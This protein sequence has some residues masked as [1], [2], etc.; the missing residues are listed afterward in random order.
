MISTVCDYNRIWLC[1]ILDSIYSN[2]I[3][4]Y[5]VD[6]NTDIWLQYSMN[7]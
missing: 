2:V 6:T 7:D 1:G 4:T 3:T 5:C